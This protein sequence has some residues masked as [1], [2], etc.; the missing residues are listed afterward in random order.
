[1]IELMEGYRH[2][3]LRYAITSQAQVIFPSYKETYREQLKE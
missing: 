1:M 2:E 3:D